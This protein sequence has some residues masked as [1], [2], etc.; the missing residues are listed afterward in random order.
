MKEKKKEQ[1]KEQNNVKKIDRKQLQKMYDMMVEYEEMIH[2]QNQKRIKNGLRCIYIIPAV[3]LFLMF[4]TDSSKVI[5]LVL[6][7]VSLFIIAIY[8]IYVE[9]IDYN[10]QE[11]MHEIKGEGCDQ[12]IDTLIDLPEPVECK[13][14]EVVERLD[15]IGGEQK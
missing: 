2:Q 4:A 8:L 7:I 11:K 1:K 13:V 9:Y 12:K 14:S 5:F 3:F 10:L 6:W 15:S